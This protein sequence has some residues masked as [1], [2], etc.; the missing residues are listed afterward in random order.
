MTLKEIQ[1]D[2]TTIE[3]G[4][5]C[6]QVNCKGIM[7]A[8]L[9]KQIATKWPYV[10]AMYQDFVHFNKVRYTNPLGNC[11]ITQVISFGDNYK[12]WVANLFGQDD[13]GN[14]RQTNY[15]AL[16]HALCGLS[17]LM[18]YNNDIKDLKDFPVYIPKMI[19]CGLGGGDWNIVY[20]IIESIF[21]NAIICSL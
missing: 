17:D 7:G 21:P 1:K 8:G 15:H 12:V 11:Y 16:E 9:A 4:I 2:I 18:R 5:I 3:R 20:Q 14:G 19:G 6:H 10:E 13:F